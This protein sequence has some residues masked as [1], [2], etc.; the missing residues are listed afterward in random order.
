MISRGNRCCH[1]EAKHITECG[2]EIVDERFSYC[3]RVAVL[4]CCQL[5]RREVGD[6][7]VEDRQ[8]VHRTRFTLPEQ[9]VS[10]KVGVERCACTTIGCADGPQAV[11]T[12]SEIETLQGVTLYAKCRERGHCGS[13]QR[14]V[15]IKPQLRIAEIII[16]VGIFSIRSE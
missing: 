14:V 3:Q 1:I 16:H 9:I 4:A 11:V 10:E 12:I 13:V 6:S 5:I 15:H 7:R 8:K 2:E